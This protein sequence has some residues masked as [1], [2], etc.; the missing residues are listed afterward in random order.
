MFDRVV[1]DIKERNAD[2]DPDELM[3]L[4]DEVVE[5]ARADPS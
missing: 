5:R 1:R 4:I 3:K 2:T